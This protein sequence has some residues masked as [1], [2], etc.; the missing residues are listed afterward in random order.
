MKPLI[1]CPN[2]PIFLSN[3]F[4]QLYYYAELRR[5]LKKLH[6]G[7][8]IIKDKKEVIEKLQVEILENMEAA[9]KYSKYALDLSKK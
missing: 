4:F 1:L 6:F 9:R 8:F 2:R 7:F 3:R 5:F